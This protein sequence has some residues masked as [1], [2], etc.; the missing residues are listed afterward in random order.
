MILNDPKHAA[1]F[2]QG[3]RSGQNAFLHSP[4]VPRDPAR[5]SD[6]MVGGFSLM[7]GVSPVVCTS[8]ENH[9]PA[10]CACGPWQFVGGT[11]AGLLILDRRNDFSSGCC[12][13]TRRASAFCYIGHVLAGRKHARQHASRASFPEAVVAAGRDEAVV[14]RF[15]SHS[16]GAAAFRPGR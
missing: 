2:R 12:R 3:S 4:F 10:R 13:T 7:V 15:T 9:V 1:V 14:S 6:R 16:Q 5:A 8:P 11:L